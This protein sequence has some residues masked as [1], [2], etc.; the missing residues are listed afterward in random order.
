MARYSVLYMH[1]NIR[2]SVFLYEDLKF[3]ALKHV[4]LVL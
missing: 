3:L 1:Y 4:E 2:Y